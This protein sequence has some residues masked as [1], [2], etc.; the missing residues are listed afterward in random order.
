[1]KLLLVAALAIHPPLRAETLPPGA[2]E[3][4]PL[5]AN[6]APGSEGRR[7]E[8]ESVSDGNVTN[9][10]NP[11]ITVFL[12][13]TGRRTGAGVV[14]MPGGGHR[15]LLIDREGYAVARWLASQGIAAFVLKYRLARAP[16]S[17]YRIEVE[18][19]ADA[20][21]S[22]RVVR[23]RCADWGLDPNHVGVLGFAAGGQLALLAAD[24]YD[25]G[26]PSAGNPVDRQSDRPAF[27]ALLYPDDCSDVLVHSNSPPAFLAAG[28]NDEPD[29]SQGIARAYLLFQ[30]VGV[31]AELHIYAGVGHGFALGPGGAESWA[32]R[33]CAWLQASGFLNG[34]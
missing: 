31:P 8:A 21:R 25:G 3:I 19:L 33:F 13:Q 28:A 4:V 1:M 7:T 9:V 10:H 16:D 2:S 17:L 29:I 22:I 18:E 12:P 11:S 26:N 34:K 15:H 14:V 5:W 6:G 20:Q 30:N 23:A 32:P 24:R 27:E